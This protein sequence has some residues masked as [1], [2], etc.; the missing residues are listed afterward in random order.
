MLLRLNELLREVML[1]VNCFPEI[2]TSQDLLNAIVDC[3]FM[4]VEQEWVDVHCKFCLMNNTL[5]TDDD[6]GWNALLITLSQLPRRIVALVAKTL[7]CSQGVI[8]SM[9]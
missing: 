6:R 8:L 4:S 3:F 1:V 5:N 7:K 9:F 2:Y